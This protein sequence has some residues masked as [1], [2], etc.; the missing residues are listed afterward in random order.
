METMKK[1]KKFLSGFANTDIIDD[2][3]VSDIKN[4]R[5]GSIVSENEEEYKIEIGI[6]Y[7]DEEDIKVAVREDKVII[8]GEKPLGTPNRTKH[9]KYKGVFE[10]PVDVLNNRLKVGFKEGLLTVILP[11]KRIVK[12]FQRAENV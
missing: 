8:N 4:L 6:P 7:M 9:R 1:S 10:L 12:Q 3:Y 11:K 5:P 2:I